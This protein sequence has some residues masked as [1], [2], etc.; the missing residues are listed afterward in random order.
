MQRGRLKIFFGYSAGVGK[1]YAMLLEAQRLKK[2]GI[3]VIIGYFEPHQ[4]PETIRLTNGLYMLPLKELEYKGIALREFDVDLAIKR[5]PEYI[6]VDELAH[7]NA[8]G[9]KNRK[10]YLDVLELLNNGINV[11]TTVNVQHL[12]TLNDII[13]SK[14]SVDVTERIPDDIFDLADEIS[15]IDL[16]PNELIERMQAGKIYKRE[17]IDLA[18][19]NFFKEDNL[20][21]L[22]ELTMRRMADRIEKQ[23]NNGLSKRRYLVL[24]S[25]SPSS[26]K[27]I[28]V[29][30]RMA[31]LNHSSF[32]AL[33]VETNSILSDENASMLKSHM[34]LV[35]SLNGDIVVKYS[36]DVI[37]AISDY[38]RISGATNLIIGKTWQSIGKKVSFENKII[39][40]LPDIEVLIVPDS[41]SVKAHRKSLFEAIRNLS[42]R[43]YLEKFR[44]ANK[45]L[46]IISNIN[47]GI[48]L[49]NPRKSFNLIVEVLSRA[50]ERGAILRI[51]DKEYLKEY[52]SMDINFFDGEVELGAASWALKNLLPAGRGTNTLRNAR[53]L[54]YPIIYRGEGIAVLGFSCNIKKL[55]ITEKLLFLQIEDTIAVIIAALINKS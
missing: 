37:E 54:Y 11:Y 14:T 28:R 15:I 16:E 30:S 13:G 47:R 4:R 32:S 40:R 22:R 23:K 1:T 38:V 55:S 31:N 46:D 18:L 34:D 19:S 5:N 3:D 45:T 48:A 36:D 42:R 21:L 20:S 49:D 6:L 29:G 44:L 24:I 53:G 35:K 43:S 8:Y 33:Y 7:T 51:E 12:E 9:S 26:A 25:P 41:Q 10:R 27:T 52:Q 17:R 50:F 2:E 39:A